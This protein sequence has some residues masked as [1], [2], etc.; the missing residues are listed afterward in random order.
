M[1]RINPDAHWRDS[2][3]PIR[4]FMMD[5]QSFYPIFLIVVWP[6]LWTLCI[7]LVA[8]IFFSILMHYG[9]TLSVFFRWLRTTVAGSRKYARPWWGV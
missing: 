7:A 1:K 2:A 9:L 8:T 3:R 4:F 6:R 5:G